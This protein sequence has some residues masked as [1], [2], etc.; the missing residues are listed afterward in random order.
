MIDKDQREQKSEELTQQFR[1]EV[2]TA[3]QNHPELTIR[4]LEDPAGP[5]TQSTLRIYVQPEQQTIDPTA[6]TNDLIK[7]LEQAA[8]AQ[9]IVDIGS[10]HEAPVQTHELRLK[11]QDIQEAGISPELISSTL[12][13]IYN[14]TPISTDRSHNAE[15]THITLTVPQSL[16]TDP[17]QQLKTLIPTPTGMQPLS[18]FVE[19]RSV[20]EQASIAHY[21]KQR[22]DIIFAELGNSSI[23]YPIMNLFWNIV[24]YNILSPEWSV[25]KW[26]LYDITLHNA[27][28]EKI[29][30]RFDGEWKITLD[31]F[32]DLGAA[33]MVSLFLIWI[34]LVLQFQ[35]FFLGNTIMKSFLLG[36]FGIFPGFSIL[37]L[38][39]GEY[40]SATAM[41]GVIALGGIAVGNAVVLLDYFEQLAQKMSWNQALIEAG[42]VRLRPIFLT[43][44]TAIL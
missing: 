7:I 23:I 18:R 12:Q 17:S 11:H 5:P 28:G 4:L 22:G 9:G 27:Q 10:S 2:L 21:K 44:I 37:Y 16:R 25:E 39:T 1:A 41:I 33:M 6:L 40:F 24:G 8:P 19:A 3:F 38:L 34:V 29:T 42:A 20:P 13:M 31:T 35:S 15:E 30:L 43:S 14:D 32:R 26:S 36:F